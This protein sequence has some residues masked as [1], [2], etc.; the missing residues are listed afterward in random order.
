MNQEN[1]AVPVLGHIDYTYGLYSNVQPIYVLLNPGEIYGS[2]LSISANSAKFKLDQHK[3]LEFVGWIQTGCGFTMYSSSRSFCTNNSKEENDNI[4]EMAQWDDD[5]HRKDKF[6]TGKYSIFHDTNTNEDSIGMDSAGVYIFIKE[7]PGFTS[8]LC[9][10]G[11]SMS[12]IYNEHSSKASVDMVRDD[13]I[14]LSRKFKNEVRRLAEETR[15]YQIMVDQTGYGLLPASISYKNEYTVDEL[16]PDEFIPVA[17]NISNFI[18]SGKSGMIILHGLQGSGKTSYIRSLIDA[19]K[20]KKFVYLPMAMASALSQPEF[21]SFMQ[22]QLTNAIL[23]IEDCEQLLESRD[24]QYGNSAIS[25]ILNMSDGLLGDG[26][27]IKFIC[28]FN[29]ELGRIDK[30]LLRKGRL[31]DKYEFGKLPKEKAQK[32]C[33]K[34]YGEGEVTAEG[35]MSL[36]EIF[37][38]DTDNHGENDTPSS[39]R[40][41]IGFY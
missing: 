2:A 39:G 26:V 22:E 36:A 4:D 12:L 33:D 13:F 28:T 10:S 17:N 16:Y 29:A 15:I 7:Y 41:R 35:D 8:V 37:Y 32:L 27:N 19:H 20:D 3:F 9:V 14:L 1:R 21:V 11:S 31:V 24:S 5:G 34:I 40:K 6:Y 30:A 18:S 38:H 23:I 25:T